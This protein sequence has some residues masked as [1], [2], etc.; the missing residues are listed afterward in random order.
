MGWCGC[1][2]WFRIANPVL[3][4]CLSVRFGCFWDRFLLQQWLS[5]RNEAGDRL[6]DELRPP[7][8]GDFSM[9]VGCAAGACSKG[10]RRR[11]CCTCKAHECSLG[12]SRQHCRREGMSKGLQVLCHTPPALRGQ[13]QTLW[14][15]HAR[16]R[17]WPQQPQPV[18]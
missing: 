12:R 6:R 8:T 5:G 15:A 1:V 4:G 11:C 7:Q 10:I 18:A 14:L 3:A 16:E 9:K 17:L 13:P 2:M